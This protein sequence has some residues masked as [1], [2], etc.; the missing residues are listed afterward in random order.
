MPTAFPHVDHWIFDLDN[1]LYPPECALFD[2]IDQNMRT[3]I[4]QR[5]GVEQDAAHIIQKQYF[6]DHGTTLAGLMAH[7][8]VDPHEFLEFVHDIEMDRLAIAPRLAPAISALPGQKILFTNGDA[9]YA[10]R[11]LAALDL[12]DQFDLICDIH[13]MEYRPKPENHAY[14]ALLQQTGINPEKSLFVEDMARNLLPAK[15]MGMTT[16]WLN[17]GSE[18]GN[19]GA[20]SDF[21][22]HE[23]GNIG[24]WLYQLTNIATE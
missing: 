23:I 5:F 16:I 13:Q 22:D 12:A 20:H 4:A 7:H 15:S 21:I 1:T 8:D 3:F 24:Q 14:D 18:Y 17:N 6:H 9:D 19:N 10:G 11:V 2:L